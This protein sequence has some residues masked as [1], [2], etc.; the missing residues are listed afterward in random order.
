MS[1]TDRIEMIKAYYA[2]MTKVKVEI[3]PQITKTTQGNVVHYA[4]DG[5]RAGYHFKDGVAYV[6]KHDVHK[7]R[8][9]IYIIH[10]YENEVNE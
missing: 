2:N 5:K 6:D 4:K 3:P 7:F 10:E 1:N 9:Q 8:G